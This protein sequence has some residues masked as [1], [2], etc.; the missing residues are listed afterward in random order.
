MKMKT[1]E[2]LNLFL[3]QDSQSKNFQKLFNNHC[4]SSKKAEMKFYADF[5]DRQETNR[6]CHIRF[7]SGFPKH[8][9]NWALGKRQCHL[10]WYNSDYN[11]NIGTSEMEISILNRITTNPDSRTRSIALSIDVKHTTRKFPQEGANYVTFCNE[12]VYILSILEKVYNTIKIEAKTFHK[13]SV[14]MNTIK[15]ARQYHR[16][17]TLS[18]SGLSIV[19][20][21]KYYCTLSIL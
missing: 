6:L 16:H 19:T 12:F 10:S 2:F 13:H 20:I 11:K 5:Y 18:P 4:R 15:N 14:I 21:C 9:R 17:T 1:L 3:N 7:P 8:L